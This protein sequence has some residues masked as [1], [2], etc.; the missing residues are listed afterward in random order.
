MAHVELSQSHT[1]L[2]LI[3]IFT[4]LWCVL[5]RKEALGW[6]VARA[7]RGHEVSSVVRERNHLQT[8]RVTIVFHVVIIFSCTATMSHFD[9]RSGVVYC[10]TPWGQWGQT[11]EEVFVEVNVPEGTRARDVRCSI[12]PRRITVKVGGEE[13]IEGRLYGTVLVDDSVWT[14]GK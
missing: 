13:V 3:L 4:P 1:T 2:R 8:C 6:R 10:E 9:E 7:L 11:I 14:L 5:N 12:H